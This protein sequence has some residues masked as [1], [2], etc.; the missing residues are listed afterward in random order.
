MGNHISLFAAVVGSGFQVFSASLLI[1]LAAI[2]GN[3]Y[4]DRGSIA[5]AAVFI[6]CLSSAWAGMMSAKTYLEY[7][8]RTNQGW[9]MTM[10]ATG[11][12]IPSIVFVVVAGLNTLAWS[13]GSTTTLGFS[14]MFSLALLLMFS[15]LLLVVGTL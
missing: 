7:E 1:I 12:L 10:L 14:T 13:Y 8:E 4:D 3:L 9:K 5:T 15:W 11:L 6:Y 2:F